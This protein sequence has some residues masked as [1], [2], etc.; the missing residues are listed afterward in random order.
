MV[1]LDSLKEAVGTIKKWIR[2]SIAT[3]IP[4]NW[5]IMDGSVVAD[6]SSPFNLAT[7]TDLRARFPRAH[8]SLTNANFGAD[9][10]YFLASGSPA[11]PVGGADTVNLSHQHAEGSHAHGIGADAISHTHG[12]NNDSHT[13]NAPNGAP[14]NVNNGAPLGK[15]DTYNHSHG[16]ATLSG[17]VSHSHGGAT[18]PN[19]GAGTDLRLSITTENRPTFTEFLHIIKVKG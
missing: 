9:T 10:N 18:F 13:H 12:I 1:N 16:G 7:L 3:P 8:N 15:I 5:L 17:G 4:P 2:P 6:A 11:L 19:N 14:A